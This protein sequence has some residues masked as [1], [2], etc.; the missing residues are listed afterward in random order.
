MRFDPM[1]SGSSPMTCGGRSARSLSDTMQASPPWTTSARGA[2]ARNWF[3][4]PHSS[5]S[6][7]LNE[8]QRSSL[9]EMSDATASDTSGNS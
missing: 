4:A 3:I 9:R 8:I 1:S 2:A 7:W 5:A 6:T